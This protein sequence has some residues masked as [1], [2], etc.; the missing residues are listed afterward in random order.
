MASRRK[1]ERIK[2]AFVVHSISIR[3]SPTSKVLPDHAR[4]VMAVLED[5]NMAHGCAQNG[6]LVCTYV[7]LQAAGVPRK[8][9]AFALRQLEVLGFIRVAERQ[10]RATI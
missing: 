7:D 3:R 8:A 10:R 4:R 2:E 1:R 9:I 6:A 5:E